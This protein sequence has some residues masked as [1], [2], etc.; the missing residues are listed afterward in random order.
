MKSI[1]DKSGMTLK[2]FSIKFEIPYNTVSQWYRG[3][4]NAP[5]WVKNLIEEKL[6]YKPLLDDYP[7]R[8]KKYVYVFFKEDKLKMRT[9]TNEENVLDTWEESLTEKE[10]EFWRKRRE[11]EYEKATDVYCYNL[12]NET[13]IK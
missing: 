12:S 1:I 4:R 13:K 6:N 3:E 8:Q 5:Q 9:F 7:T 2:E 11:E 10:N